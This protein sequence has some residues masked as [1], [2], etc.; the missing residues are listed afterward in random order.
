MTNQSVVDKLT[1][2]SIFPAQALLAQLDAGFIAKPSNKEA[3]QTIWQGAN[4]SYANNGLPSRSFATADDVKPISEVNQDNVQSM[5]DRIKLYPPYDS[6][7]TDI[8]NVRLSKLVTPQITINVNRS[9]ERAKIKPE[10]T[11]TDLFNL[12]FESAGQPQP[13]TRQVLGMSPTGGAVLFTSYDEDIRLHHPPEY[14]KISI[15]ENDIQSAKLESICLPIGGGIPFAGVYRIQIGPGIARLILNNGIHRTYSLADAGYQWC[16]MAICD[17]LPM[18]IPDPFIEI[19]KE[20]LLNLAMNPPLITDFLNGA[21]VIPLTYFHV[22]KT[23]RLNWNF[24][25]YVTVLK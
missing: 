9:K 8:L 6:H 13:I 18:E 5:L 25:Q 23:I 22:L 19:P 15:K 3:L 10:M 16:P 1:L 11:E 24:E 4:S 14:R 12:A 21:V 17:L 20:M 7:P 2:Y